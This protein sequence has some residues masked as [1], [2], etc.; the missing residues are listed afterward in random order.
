M[1]QFRYVTPKIRTKFDK[2]IDEENSNISR[3]LDLKV[4]VN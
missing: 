1:R 4:V 2:N 3:N